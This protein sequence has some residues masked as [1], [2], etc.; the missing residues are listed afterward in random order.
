MTGLNGG[1]LYHAEFGIGHRAS[2]IPEWSGV[3]LSCGHP[4]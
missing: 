4:E 3:A 1:A 2:A